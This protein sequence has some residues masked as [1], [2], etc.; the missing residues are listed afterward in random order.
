M[1][2]GV[3]VEIEEA[4]GETVNLV[5]GSGGIFEIRKDAAV[6]YSKA[7]TGGFPQAGEAAGLVG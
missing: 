6:V 4:T 3:P 7:A 2:F 5:P 1:S